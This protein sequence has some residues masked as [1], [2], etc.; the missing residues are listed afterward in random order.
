MPKVLGNDVN[1][2]L[3][4]NYLGTATT[5]DSDDILVAAGPLS[6]QPCSLPFR[7][8]L[9]KTK[10]QFIVYNETFRQEVL[11]EFRTNQSDFCSG[12]YFKDTE[13]VAATKKFAERVV[14][15]SET[16]Q[17]LYREE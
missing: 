17:S 16:L 14:R 13:L 4:G 12:D 11:S 6:K 10:T 5:T 8:V 3:V 15:K 9:V 7:V 1:G 2:L